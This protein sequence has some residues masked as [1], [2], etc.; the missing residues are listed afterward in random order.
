MRTIMNNFEAWQEILDEW[1]KV[2]K[3]RRLNQRLYDYLGS[4][5]IYLLEYSKRNDIVLPHKERL[6]KMIDESEY[7]IDQINSATSPKN[8][9]P[10]GTPEDSTKPYYSINCSLSAEICNN[11]VISLCILSKFNPFSVVRKILAPSR[12]SKRLF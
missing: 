12:Y 8:Q 4:S 5:I 10:N 3:L 1:K 9:H 2:D 6:E 11:S 7:I